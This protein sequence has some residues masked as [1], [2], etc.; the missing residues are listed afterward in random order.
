ML[1][2]KHLH[3]QFEHEVPLSDF[4][5][6]VLIDGSIS[7]VLCWLWV[8]QVADWQANTLGTISDIVA[9]DW[10]CVCDD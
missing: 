10:Q 2:N 1:K 6:P 4:L 5:F 3:F 8:D 9:G 7:N